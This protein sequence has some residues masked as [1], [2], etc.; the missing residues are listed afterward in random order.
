MNSVS[1]VGMVWYKPEN[2]DRLMALFEDG[3][4]LHRTY[5][6]WLR[7]A[8][9]GRDHFQNLGMRVICVDIDP[10]E[11]PKWCS[12]NG[13]KLNAAARNRFANEVAARLATGGHISGHR[14]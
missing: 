9:R 1:I 7:D 10:D 12:A 13:M 5:E 6:H 3:Q 14:H 8:E 4:K 2:F 11:F